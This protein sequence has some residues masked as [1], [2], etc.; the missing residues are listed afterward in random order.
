VWVYGEG[1]GVCVCVSVCV[2]VCVCVC[3]CGPYMTEV[4]RRLTLEGEATNTPLCPH[5]TPYAIH[6]TPYTIR[7][8]YTYIH[9]GC[10]CARRT[11]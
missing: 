5:H 6:H 3:V 4:V 8:I 1:G 2:Y 7:H 10:T 11:G 9:T